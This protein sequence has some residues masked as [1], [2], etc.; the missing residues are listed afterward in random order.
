M[1]LQPGGRIDPALGVTPVRIAVLSVSDT[2]DAE[3]DT[4][5]AIRAVRSSSRSPMR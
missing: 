1:S 2:R 5:G 3:G 4:S